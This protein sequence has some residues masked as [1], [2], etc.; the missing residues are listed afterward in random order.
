M[1]AIE[2]PGLRF[3]VIVYELCG[4]IDEP[5]KKESIRQRPKEIGVKSARS[6]SPRMSI[7]VRLLVLAIKLISREVRL[8]SLGFSS[9]NV[10]ACRSI[11]KVT[12]L[13]SLG[14]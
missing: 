7:L 5:D 1:F 6:F 4:R 9:N 10:A 11:S 2:R 12:Q 13:T 3:L 14:R 8:A